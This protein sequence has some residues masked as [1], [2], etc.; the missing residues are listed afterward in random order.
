MRARDKLGWSIYWP[1]VVVR[2]PL[3]HLGY[4]EQGDEILEPV[5]WQRVSWAGHVSGPTMIDI[6]RENHLEPF[7]RM[8]LAGLTECGDRLSAASESRS[9]R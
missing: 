1:V 5:Q 4:D 3:F 2:G 6:V 8:A 9:R 7:G